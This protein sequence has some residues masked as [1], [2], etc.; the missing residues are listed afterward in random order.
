[1][2]RINWNNAVAMII[3]FTLVLFIGIATSSKVMASS[4]PY[5]T[6]T[7]DN[8]DG[9]VKTSDAYTPGEQ[10]LEAGGE[11]FKTL[12]YVYVDHEDYIYI[13]DSGRAKV[14]IFDKD[15]NFIDVIE[16]N[17]SVS[18]ADDG[19]YAVNSIYVTEEK[20]YIPDSFRNSVFVFDREAILNRDQQ[21]FLW[22][23]DIDDSDSLST[24]D[25]F[26]LN[27]EIDGVSTPIGE[28]VFVVE[29][30]GQNADNRDI[31]LFKDYETGEEL[32]TKVD[33]AEMIGKILNWVTYDYDGTDVLKFN[34]YAAKNEP[35]QVITTPTAPVFQ[36]GYL[37]A[38]KK[39]VV[40]TRGN[41]Y[42]VGAQSNNGLIM[43]N[44]EGEFLTFFGGNPLRTPFID[45]IRSFILTDIQKE[46]LRNEN[47]I[48]IDYVSSVA[49]D[50][51]GF[52]YTV[53]STLEND[54]I[55]KYNV[56][57]KNY[58]SSDALGWVGA[59]DLWVGDYG[60]VV[61]VEEFGWINEYN[62]NGQLIFTFSVSDAG[63]DR[64][65]LLSL[66]KSIAIDSK[67]RLL[68]VD[69]GNKLLQIYEPTAFTNAVHTALQAYQDGDEDLA[70]VN[71][72]STLEY[73][74]IFDLAHIGLGDAYIRQGDY[75]SALV[76]YKLASYKAG[77]SNTYWQV[78]QDWMEENLE[79]VF[80][81]VLMLFVGRWIFKILNKKYDYTKGLRNKFKELR[82]KSRTVDEL[83][84]IPEFIKHPLDGYY[85]IKRKDRVSVKTATIIYGM[86]AVVFVMYYEVTNIIFLEKTNVNILY[87]LIILGSVLILW[88]IA[89]YFICLINDG[90]GSFKN[91]YVSTA[92]SFTPLLF[93]APVI[94]LLSN[95]L[96]YQEA[97]FYSVPLAF[98]LIWVSIYFFFMIKEIHNYE[99]G[100][101]VNIIFKSMF[102]MLIMGIFVFVVYSLNSQIFT[103]STEIARELI[104]R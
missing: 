70:R 8:E 21:Y 77:I 68:V 61:V 35:I 13:T 56:S 64:V 98:T 42:I 1:M 48:S 81:V 73:A 33:K 15:L 71:W 2:K 78:R 104:E 41:L 47:L 17:G 102:T 37:F 51:K 53:T 75:E 40:D 92:M 80:F 72:K 60:N 90:E 12:E 82:T 28:P 101:T 6:Y 58:F 25:V 55:K 5:Y 34:I 84:Y 7:T 100:E 4:T 23:E 99:V 86:L 67:D 30:T 11:S 9:G 97:V 65:G 57:G 95:V 22:M 103:V 63:I 19:F 54:V 10:I 26:Y 94:I 36:E 18:G 46:K 20:I 14:F 66:P 45:Q 3:L 76:E 49:I 88:V 38:P 74:T 29:V 79:L 83:S 52:I 96:T 50:E 27:E 69:Q 24:G 62:S 16:Y 59:V 91:V 85:Q 43:L 44:A 87:E 89:N 32:F 93:V 39:V 31:V